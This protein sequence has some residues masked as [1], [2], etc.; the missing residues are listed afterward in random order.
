M[1]A[2]IFIVL[3]ALGIIL[4][5]VG[6]ILGIVDSFQESTTWGLLYLLVPFASLVY[7]IKF[8]KP[9]KNIRKAF[10]LTLGGSVS[11]VLGSVIAA[12]TAPPIDYGELGAY[13]EFD[14]AEELAVTA[15]DSGT[16]A[17]YTTTAQND[18]FRDAINLATDASNRTQTAS[19]KEEWSA[20]AL[21]WQDSIA[22]L[23]AVPEA[24]PN[25]TTAQSKI[26]SYSQNLSYAQQ[27]AK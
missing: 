25:Y 18:P 11:I 1:S 8:W 9:R 17:T 20:I 22:L 21:T 3:F 16:S 7:T 2:I 5:L 26:T 15:A 23:G 6:G 13:D 10:F 24:D 19:S 4:A 14:F 12:I 27:N